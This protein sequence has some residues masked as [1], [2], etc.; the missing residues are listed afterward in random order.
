MPYSPTWMDPRGQ[1]H[2]YQTTGPRSLHTS[3]KRALERD[4]V[5][6]GIDPEYD[7][8]NFG[9]TERGNVVESRGVPWW[10][11]VA[12]L[13]GPLAG[14]FLPGMF[15][16]GA[17]A[18]PGSAVPAATGGASAAGAA[19]AAGA[20]GIGGFLKGMVDSPGDI[21]GLAGVIAALAGGMRGGGGQNSAEAQRLNQITEQRMRRVDPLHQAV[22]QLA[23]GRLPINARQNITAPTYEPLK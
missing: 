14:A 17:A 8:K 16:A 7:A 21:A 13:G 6:S 1:Q 9:V 23:W 2:Q 11:P 20:G 19:G 5:W 22:T 15:G 18:A 4:R 3:A 12:T 10:V